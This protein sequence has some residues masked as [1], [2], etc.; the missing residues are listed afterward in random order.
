MEADLPLGALYIP[1]ANK[2]IW[3]TSQEGLLFYYWVKS[4]LSITFASYPFLY[5]LSRAAVKT[6]FMLCVD[7]IEYQHEKCI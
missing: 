6:V 4:R 3:L 2:L 5:F 1:T 7:I